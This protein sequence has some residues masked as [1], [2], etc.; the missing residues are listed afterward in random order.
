[1]NSHAASVETR[2][3]WVV[4][5]VALIVLSV[6][7][8]AP[9]TTMVAL[10]PIA[11]EFGA[12]RS[13]PA[14][15]VAFTFIGAGCGSIAMG[16]LAA[17]IGVRRVVIFGGTMIG[18]GLVVASQG[19]LTQLYVSSFLLVGLLGASGLFAPLMT[20]VSAWFDRRRGTAIALI[21]AGQYIAGAL[22]P[23][24]F[25]YSIDTIGW[26]HTMLAYGGLT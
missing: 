1:M 20:Y 3:S 9:L 13:A 14:A 6:S 5:I 8:G 23:A 10:K 7:Y 4:A 15:A 12:A 16:W 25:Q 11:E 22:W 2:T 24:L 19:G 17:R 18:I 21:S 26:R